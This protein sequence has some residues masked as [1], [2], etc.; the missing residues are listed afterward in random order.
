MPVDFNAVEN[1]YRRLSRAVG[2]MLSELNIICPGQYTALHTYYKKFD[3][4]MRFM[5]LT[6]PP[7]ADPPYVVAL[8]DRP[9]SDE[10]LVGG[11]AANLARASQHLQLPIP[12]GFAV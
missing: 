7:T 1:R 4:Y 12:S 2:H 9:A 3:Q 8:D 10:S 6:E 5:L 11:K